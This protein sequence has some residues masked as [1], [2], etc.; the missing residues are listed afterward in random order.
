MRG[1]LKVIRP[2]WHPVFEPELA[3]WERLVI[4]MDYNG[5]R[6]GRLCVSPTA[7]TSLGEGEPQL[8]GMG[9]RPSALQRGAESTAA[10]LHREPTLFSWAAPATAEAA[11]ATYALLRLLCCVSPTQ[12]GT[13]VP[14][15]RLTELKPL[16]GSIPPH[17]L[18]LSLVKSPASVTCA[19]NRPLLRSS[20]LACGSTPI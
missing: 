5:K 7:G 3:A 12:Q 14:T 16:G 2:S 19:P 6:C 10:V 9:A 18:W 15:L 1:L 13:L 17:Q 20:L 11:G 8:P 4:I